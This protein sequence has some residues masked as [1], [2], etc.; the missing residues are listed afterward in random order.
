M[1]CKTHL[2]F[3]PAGIAHAGGQGNGICGE[4]MRGGERPGGDDGEDAEGANGSDDDDADAGN[5]GSGCDEGGEAGSREG[6]A[7]GGSGGGGGDGRDGADRDGGGASGHENGGGGASHE[8]GGGGRAGGGRAGGDAG[9]VR[10]ADKDPSTAVANG[11][12]QTPGGGH[13][14]HGGGGS[15]RKFPKTRLWRQS[16]DRYAWRADVGAAGTAARVAFN[17]VRPRTRPVS[18]LGCRVGCDAAAVSLLDVILQFSGRTGVC[19]RAG[20]AA[21]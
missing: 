4:I 18:Y 12:G 17:A 7:D 20:G 5:G 6:F 11:D 16:Q 8:G 19:D 3:R 15:A 13:G 1:L 2:L 10:E 14:G 21:H 9:S